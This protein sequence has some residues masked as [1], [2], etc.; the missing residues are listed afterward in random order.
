MPPPASQFCNLLDVY[1]ESGPNEGQPIARLTDYTS[2]VVRNSLIYTPRL[3]DLRFGKQTIGMQDAPMF[4]TSQAGIP[5]FDQLGSGYPLAEVWIDA[6]GVD[7]TSDDL[8][9]WRGGGKVIGATMNKGGRRGVVEVRTASV[10]QL[11]QRNLGIVAGGLCVNTYGDE[12]CG[13]DRADTTFQ[14]TVVGVN[15]GG[16]P[17]HVGVN[18]AGTPPM[19]VNEDWRNG[20]LTV[21][22]GRVQIRRAMGAMS[23]GD[24]TSDSVFDTYHLAFPHSWVGSAVVMRQGCDKT[25]SRCGRLENLRRRRAIGENMPTRQPQFQDPAS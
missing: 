24:L 20:D 10:K 18:F 14:G 21:N 17:G 4:V 19:I 2:S 12:F 23:S 6:Y 1:W 15:F 7:P 25:R 5:I 22:G 16:A 8:P 3:F 11:T 13:L 9:C